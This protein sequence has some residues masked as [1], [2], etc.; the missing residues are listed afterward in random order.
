M[1]IYLDL[2]DTLI[3]S[4]YGVGRNPG[5]R[6]VIHLS[7]KEV[8]HTLL[9]PLAA[10]ILAGLRNIRQV[11]MLTTAIKEYALAQNQAFSLGFSTQDIIARE[12][13]ITTVN[14]M[15]GENW[16]PLQSRT[17][18]DSILIDNLPPAA[19]S[20]RLK[21]QF[22]GIKQSSYFQIREFYGKEPA[23]F[24]QEVDDL[25]AKISQHCET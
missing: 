17:D 20:S 11:K 4:V 21:M 2:D 1:C 7:D 24:Q 16:I 6:T 5:K 18:P 13:Y 19:E 22:L 8:Y 9:R 25:L 15:F 23:C 14:D 3:H 12:D 10:D